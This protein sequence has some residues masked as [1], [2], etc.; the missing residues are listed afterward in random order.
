MLAPA[1]EAQR[2]L[3]IP[4]QPLLDALAAFTRETGIS[5]GFPGIRLFQK[6]SATVSG[7][8]DPWEALARLLRNSGLTFE[9]AGPALAILRVIRKPAQ[10][11]ALKDSRVAFVAEPPRMEEIRVRASKR[12]L[13]VIRLPASTAMV[14]AEQMASFGFTMS[15]DLQVPIAGFTV[16]GSGPGRNKLFL[17]GLSDGVFV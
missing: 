14:T 7:V 4:E 13:P 16:V 15:G 1:Q 6:R 11:P 8:S 17:R 5:V 9:R 12:N 10:T 2:P 3:N